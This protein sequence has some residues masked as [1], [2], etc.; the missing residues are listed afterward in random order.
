MLW[1]RVEEEEIVQ[2]GT[3]WKKEKRRMEKG[4]CG[5]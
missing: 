4:L 3:A 1:R 2:K 5:S